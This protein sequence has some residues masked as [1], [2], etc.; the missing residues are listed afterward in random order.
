MGNGFAI[1]ADNLSKI[2]KLYRS[3]LDRLRESLHPLRHEYH[4]DFYALND[5][6]F[7]INKGESVGIIGKNGSGKSTLLKILTGVIT[8]TT[9]DVIVNGKVSALLEL[10]AGFNPELSGLENVFFNGM[11][12]GYTREEMEERLDA[13]LSFADIGEF[14]NQPVK[15]YSSGMFVRLAFAV[16]INVD[17]DILIVDEALSVGDELFQRKCFARIKEFQALGKTT[18]FVSHGAA[19]IIE[20]C[21][22]AMMLDEGHLIVA[23]KPKP[24]FSIYQ[25]ILYSDVDKRKLLLSHLSNGGI[26]NA[27][28]IGNPDDESVYE[29]IHGND[30][31]INFAYY[32]P[33]LIPESKISYEPN[34]AIISNP[35]IESTVGKMVNILIRGDEYLFSYEADFL[36]DAHNVRFGMLLKTLS[37]LEIFGMVSHIQNASIP[38]IKQGHK[39]KQSFRFKCNLMPGSY[40]LNAGVLGKQ[41]NQEVFLHRVVDLA[42]FK[43]QDEANSLVSGI[44]DLSCKAFNSIPNDTI[45]NF[46]ERTPKPIF[47]SEALCILGMHRSGT[48]SVSRA[49]NLLGYYLGEDSDII[50]A[51]PENP[52]GFWEHFGIVCVQQ[53]ILK[54]LNS[55]WDATAPVPIEK[56]GSAQLSTD[57]TMLKNVIVSVLGVHQKWMWKDPRTC[58]LMPLWIDLLR[59]MNALLKCVFVIR[60][61]LDVACSLLKRNGFTL[62]KGYKM[63][64]I[65]NLCA[66]K[67]IDGQRVAFVSY[68]KYLSD[69]EG[70]TKRVANILDI[71]WPK[72]DDCII[73]SMNEFIEPKLQHSKSSLTDLAQV[74]INVKMLY[75]HLLEHTFNGD[76]F[77]KIPDTIK[78][79]AWNECQ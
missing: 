27:D 55:D 52:K 47:T 17:P 34:G 18:L 66:L 5:V 6:S 23:G 74:P 57:V 39:Y 56:L 10:G 76:S 79:M 49:F 63:W 15:T 38:L 70:E 40:F 12:M 71:D 7:E 22:K 24:V 53:Q 59:E 32:L 16:A 20:L 48:S 36:E 50:N 28:N 45:E 69:W 44:V 11:L 1:K 13:V 3:P 8:P 31:S 33:E 35:I 65:N 62:D 29:N 61:P 60:N 46:K 9:G 78:T 77:Y 30:E 54:R 43:V 67:S 72:D 73:R 42:L 75:E 26:S 4:H 2:Y 37:G 58:L 21:D 19:I 25:R 14:V 64:L 51:C 68:E 41:N